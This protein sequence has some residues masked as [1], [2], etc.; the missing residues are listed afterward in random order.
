MSLEAGEG[1]VVY[2]HLYTTISVFSSFAK[3]P[4]YCTLPN[5]QRGVPLVIS[6]DPKGKNFL[7][8]CGKSVV[9]RDIAV[10]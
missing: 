8:T 4:I 3:G 7:Y 10:S 5:A 2:L 6:G 1:E 9:I